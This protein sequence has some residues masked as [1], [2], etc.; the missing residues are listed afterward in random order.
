M[1]L[2]SWCTFFFDILSVSRCEQ[3]KRFV[4]FFRIESLYVLES[5]RAWHHAFC[6]SSSISYLR[7]VAGAK[8]FHIDR[9]WVFF[10][11]EMARETKSE[12]R[13]KVLETCS[14]SWAYR[15][16]IVLRRLL[17]VPGDAL[18]GLWDAWNCP[19]SFR[20]MTREPCWTRKETSTNRMIHESWIYLYL[21]DQSD[22]IH[23]TLFCT[24]CG[25]QRAD[26]PKGCWSISCR[27]LAP[28]LARLCCRSWGISQNSIF[29]ASPGRGN[30]GAALCSMGFID[31]Y[32]LGSCTLSDYPC[33]TLG[34]SAL[35]LAPP[36]PL[37]L[38]LQSSAALEFLCR[39]IIL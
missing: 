33:T 36:W 17:P 34:E 20:V 13:D 21:Y 12:D 14:L 37:H 4:Q 27:S 30:C 26:V 6:G 2:E 1:F 32:W 29:K 11:S 38:Y 15:G 5:W 10:S 23:S 19:V 7:T 24:S 22:R 28:M 35:G 3:L 39:N 9:S 31:V 25:N 8:F 16:L 18:Y